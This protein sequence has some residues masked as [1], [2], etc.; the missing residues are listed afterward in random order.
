[1]TTKINLEPSA[2]LSLA[3]LGQLVQQQIR[4]Q[5]AKAPQQA[6]TDELFRATAAGLRPVLMDA[7]L[8]S[9]S[10]FAGAD[11]KSMYYLSMEFLLGRSLGNNLQNLGIYDMMETA[12]A[13]WG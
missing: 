12:L 5:F 2:P 7:L 3:T 4:N 6:T 9:S 13:N 1:M 11:A 8:E 10:R